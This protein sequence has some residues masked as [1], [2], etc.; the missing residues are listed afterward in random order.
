MRTNDTHLGDK[1]GRGL[2][3]ASCAR[4]AHVDLER[5][6]LSVTFDGFTR[7]AATTGAASLERF[8]ARGTFYAACGLMGAAAD[9]PSFTAEDAKRLEAAGHEIGCHTYSFLDCMKAPANEVLEEC[10]RNAIEL[11]LAGAQKPMRSI[12]FPFGEPSGRLKRDLP[13]DFVA[14]RGQ[15]P[16]LN[17]GRV[18][19]AQLKSFPVGGW[20]NM[21]PLVLMLDK[22]ARTGAWMIVHMQDLAI[23]SS[24][25]SG[26]PTGV[27][28]ALLRRA[29][30]LKVDI[31]PVGEAADI[32]L[33]DQE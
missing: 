29:C 9:G 24:A 8:Y 31:L 7:S 20:D 13:E 18:D 5:A 32:I 4:P 21:E 27:L 22:A 6:I 3:R 26:T 14:G 25:G 28:G 1:I 33:A 11:A 12:A 19:M 15:T 23:D 2:V 10:G 17:S 16:G 30:E